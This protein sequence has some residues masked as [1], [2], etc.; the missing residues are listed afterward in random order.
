MSFR[1]HVLDVYLPSTIIGRT[2]IA[3]SP[4]SACP[5]HSRGQMRTILSGVPLHWCE[6][7][8]R[9]VGRR[10]RG[11]IDGLGEM[12]SLVLRRS[13]PC[14]LSPPRRLTRTQ[15]VPLN[16]GRPWQRLGRP[17]RFGVRVLLSMSIHHLV[18][19][20]TP[21]SRRKHITT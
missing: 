13:E 17:A 15:K 10:S 2:G 19:R 1:C 6:G 11:C 7:P 3:R 20:H 9:L 14:G 12:A 4:E 21:A 18:H 5:F 8:P 16:L